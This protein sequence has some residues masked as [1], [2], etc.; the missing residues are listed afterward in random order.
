MLDHKSRPNSS[1]AVHQAIDVAKIA[2]TVLP[3][4]EQQAKSFNIV[5]ATKIKRQGKFFPGLSFLTG[6]GIGSGLA[7]SVIPSSSGL[8]SSASSLT[9]TRLPTPAASVLTDPSQTIE[10]L[11]LP[12]PSVHDPSYPYYFALSAKALLNESLRSV[13]QVIDQLKTEI[14][15]KELQSKE[16][17]TTQPAITFSNEKIVD[18]F[19]NDDTLQMRVFKSRND[20]INL[21]N[22]SALKDVIRATIREENVRK[23]FL[24]LLNFP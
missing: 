16:E 2:S 24:F 3:D 6:L 23:I 21:V 10:Q 14:A 13:Y 1:S 11:R 17:M 5:E 15:K 8:L 19:D 9:G 20:Q 4:H 22:C 18:E 12:T 7:G